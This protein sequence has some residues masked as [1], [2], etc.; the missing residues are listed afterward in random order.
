MLYRVEIKLESDLL[1]SVP[2]DRDVY[3]DY[4]ASKIPAPVAEVNGHNLDADIAAIPEEKRGITGFFKLPDG[5]PYLGR[6]VV[7]GF[8]KSAVAAMRAAESA[9]ATGRAKAGAKLDFSSS[10]ITA[11]ASKIDMLVSVWPL[12]IPL[13][14]A[15]PLTQLSR[16]LRAMTMQGPR[17]AL[18][19]SEMAPA[20]T[21]LVC[22]VGV[23]GD[24]TITPDMVQEIFDYGVIQGL[25]QWRGSGMYGQFTAEVTTVAKPQF[26]PRASWKFFGVRG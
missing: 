14:L 12:Q 17:V 25:G 18:A 2:L 16:P 22:E 26:T 6:H 19:S 4:I 13:L 8:M 21:S 3:I 5:R 10:A 11:Y 24:T 20:G 23:M 1:G 15:G 9:P 7:K